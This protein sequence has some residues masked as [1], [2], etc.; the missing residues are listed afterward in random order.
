VTPLAL[1]VTGAGVV[2]FIAV[3][4][5]TRRWREALGVM[6][7]LWLAAGLLRLAAPPTWPRLA[8]AAAIIAIRQLTGF[9]LRT[10][11]KSGVDMGLRGLFGLESRGRAR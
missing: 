7:E 9:G 6:L 10:S 4:V 11:K 5:G 2:C 3:I 8:T 1:G